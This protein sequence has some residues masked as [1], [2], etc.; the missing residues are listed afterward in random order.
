MFVEKQIKLNIQLLNTKKSLLQE[1]KSSVDIL[2]NQKAPIDKEITNRISLLKLLY[3]ILLVAAF[4][5]IHLLIIKF[6]WND[7][8]QW[9][10]IFFYSIPLFISLIYMLVAEKTINPIQL[11]VR[12]KKKIKEKKYRKFNFDS[13]LLDRLNKAVSELENEIKE[14]KAST[15]QNL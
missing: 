12:Q 13:S 8:E 7:S 14:L 9:T 3:S 6:G 15:Q 2:E 5:G 11:L 1:K 4:I 10:W